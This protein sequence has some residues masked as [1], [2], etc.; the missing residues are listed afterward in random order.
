MSPAIDQTYWRR[1]IRRGEVTFFV[2]AG[3][4][5]AP[6][7]S[8]PLATGL[9]ASLIAPVLEPLML[10]AGLARSVVRTLVQ[11]RPEVITDVLL[12]HLGIDAARPLLRVL[13]GEPNAWHGLLAAALGTGCCVVTTN[14]DTLIEKAGDAIDG[15]LKDG[16]LPAY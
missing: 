14:F 6:P 2:G 1:A 8:L 13:R 9:V 7:A 12:E 3:I 15:W 4:S 5:A 16:T 11:L 10:P